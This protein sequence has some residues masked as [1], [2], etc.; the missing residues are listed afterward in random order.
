MSLLKPRVFY[1]MALGK[2][3]PEADTMS[4]LDEIN[5]AKEKLRGFI[6]RTGIIYSY[7]FSKMIGAQIFLKAENMQ[8]TGSFKIRGA[9]NRI[10]RLNDE[11][12]KYG[13]IAVSAGN[14]AQGVALAASVF[15]IKATV[16]MPES[17]PKNKVQ[18][19]R[20]YGAEV[21][22]HG[23]SIEESKKFALENAKKGQTFIHPYDD[24]MVIAGQGTI[25]L[26]MIEDEPQLDTIIVPVGGGGLISGIAIALKSIKPSIR[27]IGVEIKGYESVRLSI[28]SGKIVEVHGGTTIADGIAINTC[29]N[30]PYEIIRKYVDD[31]VTVSEKETEESICLLLERSKL[32]TEGAGAIGMAA[33]LSGEIKARAGER[34]GIVLS[35]GNIELELLRMMIENHKKM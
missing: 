3:R 31:I 24:P 12:R 8:K 10:S 32:L 20:N 13:V 33:L 9:Y 2:L 5:K 7:S 23:N 1:V 21:I 26:E 35:G 4:N 27:L 14:H 34:I 18:A 30:L 19:T 17:V 16:V 22:M 25:G 6:N 11:E 15:G 28:N 29:G